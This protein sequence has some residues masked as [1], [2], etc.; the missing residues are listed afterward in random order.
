ML[1]KTLFDY[2][3]S[4]FLLKTVT[5]SLPASWPLNSYLHYSKGK[6]G[7][8]VELENSNFQATGQGQMTMKIGAQ[9]QEAHFRLYIDL[10]REWAGLESWV[11]DQTTLIEDW[12]STSIFDSIA[13]GIEGS[14]SKYPPVDVLV[15]PRKRKNVCCRMIFK[16]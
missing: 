8:G 3:L 4:T 10:D 11:A 9:I 7:L 13:L 12:F 14:P 15:A 2:W 6:P 1:G 16:S 5:A